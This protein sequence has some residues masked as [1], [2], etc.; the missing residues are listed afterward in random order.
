VS[1]LDSRLGRAAP[2][3]ALTLLAGALRF[4]TLDV[5]SFSS[6]EAVTALL[7][8]TDLRSMLST[9]PNTE[10]TPP[11]YYVAAWL[12][13]QVF[14]GGEMG[15]RSLSAVVGTATIPIVYV[16]GKELV[17]C[18]VGLAAAAVA[19]VS[20]MLVS[21]AQ[22]ARSYALLVAL[23]GLSFALFVRARVK[24]KAAT[25]AGWCIVSA[26]AL[27]THYFA[28]FVVLPEALLL[29]YSW[30][31]RQVRIAVAALVA[32]G[33]ALLPLALEQR[34][35]R[36]AANIAAG[37]PLP[38]RIVILA[39]QFLIGGSAPHDRIAAF[40]G[41]LLLLT[42]AVLVVARGSRRVRTGAAIAAGTGG[43]AIV[44]PAALALLG[45]DYLITRNA[46]AGFVPLAI[47]GCAGV[48]VAR[49]G[50]AWLGLTAACALLC[51][52]TVAVAVDPTYQRPDWR[53][54]A[55]MMEQPAQPKVL[56]VAPNLDGWSA[57]VP[58]SLYLPEAVPIGRELLR[59]APQFLPLTG[60]E[61]ELAA[62]ERAAVREIVV[63][64]VQWELPLP[65]A[66]VPPAFRLVDERAT[67][68]YHVAVYRSPRTMVVE[69]GTL[70]AASRDAAILFQPGE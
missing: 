69:A 22:E 13:T 15:L 18:S 42:S 12:W 41:G 70:A 67:D 28:A 16:A 33:L 23:T 47:A 63:A 60:R 31:I 4:S 25:L 36:L 48:A 17:S 20:P 5:Q 45:A 21:Y 64:G 43:C 10:S 11:L 66:A 6:D 53:G 29:L 61:R 50:V 54:F 55:R 30:R 34:E 9:L 62:P 59:D 27:T 38:S 39:K 52:I 35:N 44:L 40:V 56:V 46:L 26:L 37:D 65:R 57:R 24:P 1:V 3:V 19:A 2:I 49:P 32:G 58:L 7:V 51:A 14:G 8:R 68:R